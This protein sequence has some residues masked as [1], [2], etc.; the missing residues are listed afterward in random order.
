MRKF[1]GS[2]A[3]EKANEFIQCFIHESYG[4]EMFKLIMQHTTTSA[5]VGACVHVVRCSRV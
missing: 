1:S 5:C 4:M 2:H 3:I